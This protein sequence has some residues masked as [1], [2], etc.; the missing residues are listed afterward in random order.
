MRIDGVQLRGVGP[1]E[2]AKIVFQPRKSE[3]KA[4]LHILVG[5]NGSGKSTILYALAAALAG[6]QDDLGCRHALRRMTG[7]DSLFAVSAGGGAVAFARGAHSSE[8]GQIEDPFFGGVMLRASGF[9]DSDSFLTG[10]TGPHLLQGYAA[11]AERYSKTG[12]QAP[13]LDFAAF[14]YSGGRSLFEPGLSAIEEP[15]DGPLAQA[16]SF[17]KTVDARRLSQW[18]SATFARR[19][20]A[21]ERQIADEVERFGSSIQR[22]EKAVSDVIGSPISLDID[23]RPRFRIIVERHGK[24]VDLDVLPDGLKSILSWVADLLMR[25]E[26]IPWRGDL[27][28]LDRPI[29]LFLDEIDVHLHP[30]WQRKVLPMVQKLLP[31]AQIFVTT[32]SPFVVTSVSEA[33]VYPLALNEDGSARVLPAV[34]SQAGTTYPTGTSRPFLETNKQNVF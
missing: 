20:L 33:W 32:H 25:L 23:Y 1:L 7:E 19:A 27:P 8:H 14:T 13:P 17:D 22:I 21:R 31:K 24:R 16:L 9:G 34:E 2:D 30:E 26:R 4:D 6:P 3:D 11:I 10:P 12:G 18:L 5:P 28:P 29:A 15:S